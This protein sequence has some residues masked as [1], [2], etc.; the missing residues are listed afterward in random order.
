MFYVADYIIECTT[1]FLFCPFPGQ[2]RLNRVLVIRFED[3]V[4]DLLHQLH[5]LLGGHLLLDDG[6]H[7][8]VG[9][10]E[11][12]PD[13]A[14]DPSATKVCSLLSDPPLDDDALAL[15]DDLKGSPGI[16]WTDSVPVFCVRNNLHPCSKDLVAQLALVLLG[17]LFCGL[18]LGLFQGPVDVDGDLV[19]GLRV[20][21]DGLL[22]VV[23]FV[24]AEDAFG[25]GSGHG[26]VAEM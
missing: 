23:P 6:L 5:A 25:K 2:L 12:P 7:D 19:V 14:Q 22:G 8:I 17:I 20:A 3:L 21:L 15:V 9:L 18:V 24:S 4:R 10:A 26:D 1:I 11:A 16:A 13:F